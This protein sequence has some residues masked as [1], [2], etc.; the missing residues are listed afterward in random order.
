M[1][2]K[3]KLIKE[4]FSDTELGTYTTYGIAVYNGNSPIRK[5][6]D[7]STDKHRV[8][9]LCRMCNKLKLDLEHLT[10]V[11]EDFLYA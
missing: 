11:I 4:R 3:Y 2:I 5:V 6:S 1:S 9:K 7:V 10:D 8:R